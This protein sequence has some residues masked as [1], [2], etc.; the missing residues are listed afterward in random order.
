M[1]VFFIL[2]AVCSACLEVHVDPWMYSDLAVRC[3]SAWGLGERVHALTLAGQAS[4]PS[5]P[6]KQEYVQ[7]AV[8][9]SYERD[10]FG[11]CCCGVYWCQGSI[12][13]SGNML[14]MRAFGEDV[15]SC[16]EIGQCVI[17]VVQFG[18]AQVLLC[19]WE[20]IGVCEDDSD[21][22][23]ISSAWSILSS[24]DEMDDYLIV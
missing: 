22:E 4:R 21:T 15:P 2:I 9:G 5:G 18:T 7:Q 19:F 11:G 10:L 1:C 14:E 20:A 8:D 16:G 3:A 6:Y 24:G 12:A 17:V 13:D 23:A